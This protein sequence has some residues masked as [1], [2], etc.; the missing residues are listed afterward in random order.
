MKRTLI[1]SALAAG[2]ILAVGLAPA[3]SHAGTVRLAPA[4]TLL[5]PQKASAD[6]AGTGRIAASSDG[7]VNILASFGNA[8]TAEQNTALYGS[9]ST[10]P[11][12]SGEVGLGNA[13]AHHAPNGTVWGAWYYGFADGS[14][15]IHSGLKNP[16]S[17][18]SAWT[19]QTI[20]N[21]GTRATAPYKVTDLQVTAE[22]RQGDCI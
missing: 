16:G 8:I 12:D 1:L 5:P 22:G 21:S 13:V 20:P 19:A 6:N 7:S 17:G 9:F 2:A 3:G 14:A 4:A 18:G 11:L 10:V 15:E